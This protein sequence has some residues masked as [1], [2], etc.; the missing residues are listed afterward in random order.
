MIGTEDGSPSPPLREGIAVVVAVGI[1]LLKRC[2]T[3][4]EH[5]GGGSIEDSV[6]ARR[7]YPV[8][9]RSSILIRLGQQHPLPSEL[10]GYRIKL[11]PSGVV[12]QWYGSILFRFL[13]T[14]NSFTDYGLELGSP[15]GWV[16]HNCHNCHSE[17][18]LH[19]S[20]ADR[21]DLHAQA[22]PSAVAW[23]QWHSHT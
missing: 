13:S 12:T 18:A 10:G 3:W 7:C 21:L 16:S 17:L 4:G 15:R 19:H 23:T 22:L 9:R 11:I 5:S 6:M 1:E 20:M 8:P 14:L 2:G